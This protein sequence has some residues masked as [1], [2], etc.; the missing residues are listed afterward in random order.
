MTPTDKKLLAGLLERWKKEAEAS[1]KLSVSTQRSA[2]TEE[3]AIELRAQYQSAERTY[4]NCIRDVK[5][6]FRIE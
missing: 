1:G 5:R 4:E 3:L 6:V 2:H